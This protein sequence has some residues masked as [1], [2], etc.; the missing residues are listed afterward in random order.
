MRIE[1]TRLARDVRELVGRHIPAIREN[2]VAIS[3]ADRR[4]ATLQ[5]KSGLA[6]L[7]KGEVGWHEAF[8]GVTILATVL[9]RSSGKLAFVN[10]GVT[11]EASLELDF[12]LRR[13]ARRT[14]TLVARHRSMLP[15]QGIGAPGVSRYRESGWLPAFHLMATCALALVGKCGELP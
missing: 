5:W 13:F 15:S 3:A 7:S 10:I 1:V 12:V 2:L 11:I 4:V 6:V 8:C 14:V 9:V